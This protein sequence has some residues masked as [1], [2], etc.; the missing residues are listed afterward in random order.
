VIDGNATVPDADSPNF[1]GGYLTIQIST[2]RE[3][4]DEYE[5]RDAE[6][7]YEKV[8]STMTD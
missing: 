3:F 8:Q 7:S 4:S 6:H 5:Y 1:D 2:N